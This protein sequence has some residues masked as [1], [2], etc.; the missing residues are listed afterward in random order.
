MRDHDALQHNPHVSRRALEALHSQL[1]GW[2]LS[3]CGYDAAAAEDLMQQAYVEILSGRARFDKKSAL[4]TFMFGIVQN[5]ARMHFRQ[6]ATRMRLIKT[7]AGDPASLITGDETGDHH[8]QRRI[9][10]AVE[11]LPRRQRDVTELVFCRDMTVEE[12][13]AVMG[14]TLGTARVHYDRAKKTLAENLASLKQKEWLE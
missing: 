2:A 13:S 9:W 4:K 3:R 1:F 7:Y 8:E 11:N 10:Q 12:A 6:L 14:V 5:L